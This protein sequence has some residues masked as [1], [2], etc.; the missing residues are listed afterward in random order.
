MTTENQTKTPEQGKARNRDFLWL[1][2][3]AVV[4]VVI[5][6]ASLPKSFTNWDDP[7]YVLKNPLI[8]SLSPESL[9]AML[10]TPYF[11]NYAP[12]TMFSYALD[13]R[14]W[15]PSPVAFHVH[16]VLLHI[17]CMLAL[18]ALLGAIGLNRGP[19]LLVVALFA[20]HPTNVETVSWASERKN[21]LSSLFFL[22]S[23]WQYVKYSDERRVRPYLLSLLFLVLSLGAKAGTV[24]APLVFLA[25]DYF[26]KGKK[27]REVSFLDK[28]PFAIVAA[29]HTWV[30]IHA[31]MGAD[32][33]RT[34]HSGG[35]W[36]S[37][38]G[39]GRLIGAY[40]MLLLYPRNLSPLITPDLMPSAMDWRFLL[41]L[42]LVVTALVGV[43]IRRPKQLFWVALFI[44]LLLP[45]MNFVPLP[46]Y[47]ANRYLY[48][49]QIGIWG[50]IAVGIGHWF[51]SGKLKPLGEKV[52]IAACA[53]WLVVLGISAHA[54][55]RAWRNSETL[56]SDAL[57]KSPMNLLARVSLGQAYLEA[58]RRRDASIE[59]TT[60]LAVHK[61][62]PPAL[63]G[64]ALCELAEGR[65]DE[66]AAYAMRARVANPDYPPAATIL[67]RARQ[68]QSV[69]SAREVDARALHQRAL[70]FDA[71][72]DTPLRIMKG[73]DICARGKSGHLDFLR[74]RE[75]GVDAQFFAIFLYPETKVPAR[76]A[77]RIIAR[78]E[79]VVRS[80]PDQ[81]ALARSAAEL[82][83]LSR[84]GLRAILLGIE[85]GHIIEGDVSALGRFYKLG[86]RYMTL[87]WSNTNEFADSSDGPKRWG[88]LNPLGVQV[89][90]E[91]NRL[92][93]IV[94][95]SHVSDETF[96]DVM[97][98]T[99][100]P[101]IASHSS[102]RA[103]QNLPRNMNDD[104]LRAVA[105]NGGVVC[106][107]FYPLFLGGSPP[108]KG[109]RPAAVPLSLLL[110]HIQ[111]AIRVAGINH[112]GLGSDFDGID[113][114]PTGLEDVTRMPRITEG[115][116][117]RGVSPGDIEKVLGSNLLRVLRANE[118][119]RP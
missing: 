7:K 112:V 12:L 77:E 104:M 92:G 95:V 90:R 78:I 58:G 67:A 55:A 103:L 46:V 16:N 29:A 97:K 54:W 99:T 41:P 30:S 10:V 31:A 115:L 57:R 28:L 81:A 5:Y 14:F 116:L 48:L 73:A 43:A 38:L 63:V 113:A 22:L 23:F 34:F 74:M 39:A 65:F 105:K 108:K 64:L 62:N 25:Y 56:W 36:V 109:E 106:I 86:V 76:S 98:T 87:T 70:V 8:K 110:D 42:V 21:L 94:D 3:L 79:T 27:I 51:S 20:V 44:L 89:V 61:E 114:V 85:G 75:G 49:A 84:D 107:N 24:V 37:L 32:S 45:V 4:V 6:S 52:V 83:T 96:W 33:L 100:K 9:G 118:V 91:M 80:C 60:V 59:F 19:T 71:H 88:G 2:L 50:L 66:A 47:M 93:M 53:A 11:G 26:W 111:H 72:A 18:Y 101:V 69:R 13:M 1:A 40:L 119:K 102:C 35:P 17:G 117:E 15:G 68:A 82:E